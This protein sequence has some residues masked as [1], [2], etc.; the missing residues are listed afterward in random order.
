MHESER[1][2][3]AFEADGNLYEFTR[4]PFGVAN[5]PPCFQREMDNCIRENNLKATF[6]YIDNITI[7]GTDKQ[8]HNQN[9]KRFMEMAERN[10]FT[11]NE[12]KSV[13]C[14]EEIDILGYRI[15]HQK[16]QPDPDQ[17]KPLRDLP[18]PED[19]KTLKRVLGL[20]AYYSCWIPNYSLKI[21]PLLETTQFPLSSPA[22]HCFN[23]LKQEIVAATLHGIDETLPFTVETD[24]SDF[25][26]AAALNQGGRPVAFFSRSL[27][28]NEKAHPAI[29]KEACSIVEALRK[30]KHYLSGRHFTIVTDQEAVSFIFNQKKLTK[31]KND[32]LMRWRWEL[33]EYNFDIVHRPGVEN[34]AADT[35]SRVVSASASLKDM[36][37][38]KKIHCDL[39]HPGI[40]R[41][42]AYEKAKNLPYSID[43][44]RSLVSA[45]KTCSLIKPQF[46]RDEADK[47][48]IRATHPFDRLNLDFKGKLPVSAHSKNRFILHIIDEY[49]RFPFAFACPDIEWTTVQSCLYQL[50]TL[51]GMPSYVHNDRGSSLICKD[52]K[53]WLHSLGIATSKTTPYNPQGNGQIEKYNGTLWRAISLFL[54]DKGL[55]QEH[56]EL[57]LPDALH[58]IRSLVCTATN[59][60]PHESMF[61]HNRRT[62]SGY[63]LPVWLTKPG[64][65]LIKRN[66]RSSKYE[67]LVEEA[68][69]IEANP[70]YAHVRL[71]SGLEKTVSLRQLAPLGDNQ[72]YNSQTQNQSIIQTDVQVSDPVAPNCT[73]KASVGD[74]MNEVSMPVP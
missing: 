7:C 40:V 36:E 44:V 24:A 17:L 33:S 55:G 43:D 5:G 47:H 18:P 34:A 39:L 4:V 32:K 63:S 31:I 60:T 52:L 54:A 11:F 22:L 8:D 20:F 2:F 73:D 41:F 15:S 27:N 14:Q 9:L 70:N 10:G 62:T 30:W 56:W 61:R 64:P 38:L 29:E 13:I 57:A 68:E 35:L 42:H 3:T 49:S 69:L 72:G 16:L 6:C 37:R 51:F 21:R 26:I 23:E 65:I 53:D 58:S 25:A 74:V 71:N 45:C 66:A 12:D 1:S 19:G 48:L 28:K 50:F 59:E 67:P 46:Y